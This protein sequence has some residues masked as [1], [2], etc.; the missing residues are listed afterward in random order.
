MDDKKASIMLELLH[1]LMGE[2]K[3]STGSKLK[4]T[5]SIEVTTATPLEDDK[6]G[7]EAHLDKIA[8]EPHEE[9]DGDE[10]L[11]LE[12][13]DEDEEPKEEKMSPA[14]ARMNKRL[15]L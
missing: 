11:G 3:T 5:A 8:A 4:P 2:M 9:P 1:D 15:G 12:D 13:E 10:L 14:M 7:L 6:E